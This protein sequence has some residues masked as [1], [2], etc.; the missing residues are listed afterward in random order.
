MQGNPIPTPASIGAAAADHAHAVTT[1]ALTPIN[2]FTS[3]GGAA[4]S[5][6]VYPALR[7]VLLRFGV[8]RTTYPGASVN[9][10]TWDAAYTV[11][12]GTTYAA[13]QTYDAGST[14]WHIQFSRIASNSLIWTWLNAFSGTGLVQI[15]GQIV[16][17]Y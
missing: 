1:V 8:Q 3:I 9:I 4:N 6:S 15:S 2:G 10:F 14:H 5:L 7:L 17:P 16:F 12:G 13:M 11:A